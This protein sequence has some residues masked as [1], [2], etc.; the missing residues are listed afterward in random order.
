MGFGVLGKVRG[1][2]VCRVPSGLCADWQQAA[3]TGL[4]QEPATA[5]DFLRLGV[6]D[7]KVDDSGF[8]KAC[9]WR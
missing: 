4:S 8:S 7:K 9:G 2:R 3:R 5:S 1:F 6:G